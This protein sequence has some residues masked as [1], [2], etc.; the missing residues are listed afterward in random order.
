MKTS[1]PPG[2]MIGNLPPPSPWKKNWKVARVDKVLLKREKMGY[3]R[4]RG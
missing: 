4:K 1:I 3:F 2:P